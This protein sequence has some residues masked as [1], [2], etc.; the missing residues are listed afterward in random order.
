MDDESLD[1]VKMTRIVAQWQ[2]GDGKAVNAI[3]LHIGERME[4][5]ARKMLR[6]F[7]NV[8]RHADTLDVVQ[9]ASMRLVNT[10]RNLTPA[11]MRDFYNLAAVHIRRELLDLARRSKRVR[12]VPLVSGIDSSSPGVDPA[13]ERDRDLD[14]WS[15]L[16]EEIEQLPLEL[17]ET[18][19]LVFYH[20]WSQ[21][22]IADLF[23]VDART[24][25]RRWQKACGQL[26]DRL[27]G[28]IP[29]LS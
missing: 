13:D 14:R 18:V 16:H 17:R 4:H 10:L 9:G 26:H 12:E 28:E 29:P 6:G 15:R 1:T 25:R 23:G 22:R 7:P 5:L 21:E 11:S 27:K 19:G 8:Q 3:I 20:G 2:T 24:V